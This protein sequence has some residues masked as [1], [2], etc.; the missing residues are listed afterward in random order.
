MSAR[1]LSPFGF[2]QQISLY[3]ELHHERYDGRG[4]YA[5]SQS[6]IPV[7]AHVLIAADSYD[8]MTSKRA[9]RPALT[10]QEETL[11]NQ[12]VAAW[13]Y[14]TRRAPCGCTPRPVG[15]ARLAL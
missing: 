3:A 11:S 6:E 4:Y 9:Y 10:P 14:F 8:A 13:T 2:A 1:L 12:L 5:V 7:E 15:T